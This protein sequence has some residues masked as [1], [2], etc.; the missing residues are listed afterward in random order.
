M[1]NLLP[2]NATHLERAACAAAADLA[3]VKA[4]LHTLW[5]AQRIP[6]GLLPWLAW[7]VGVDVWSADWPVQVQRDIVQDAIAVR[8]LGGTVWAVRRAL[9]AA[10]FRDVEII[11]HAQ[12]Y[13]A[14]QHAGGAYIDGG[15]LL[16][17]GEGAASGM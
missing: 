7:A 16:S 12:A 2:S 8:H 15:F 6:E 11:E 14:W 4:P 3:E 5:D 9:E 10:G 1:D 13:S 17:G